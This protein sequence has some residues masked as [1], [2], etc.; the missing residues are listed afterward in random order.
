[1]AIRR[2]PYCKAII[3]ESQKYCNNCGT[4]LLFPDDEQVDEDLK[5]ERLV[6]EDFKDAEEEFDDSLEPR[7]DENVP[8]EVIDLEAV[9]EEGTGFPDEVN[10]GEKARVRS[11]GNDIAKEPEKAGEEAPL[12]KKRRTRKA[13][14]PAP[15]APVKAPPRRPTSN[16]PPPPPESPAPPPS[17]PLAPSPTQPPLPPLPVVPKDSCEFM[18]G[19]P[20]KDEEPDLGM[21][22]D[23][24]LPPDPDAEPEDDEEAEDSEK[25]G[26]EADTKEEIARLIE[27]LDK[28]Q[29]KTG[30]EDTGEKILAPLDASSDLPAWADLSAD[31]SA[32]EPV[33]EDVEER[34]EASSFVPGDTMDFQDEVMR[35]AEAASPSKATI[36]M[37][38]VPVKKD[39]A[40]L[41]DREE[42]EGPDI[43]VPLPIPTPAASRKPTPVL[44]APE[45]AEGFDS[46]G[47]APQDAASNNDDIVASRIGLGFFRRTAAIFFDLVFVAVLW[48]T[49]VGLAS[50][51][52][53]TAASDLVLAAT[54]PLGL[55]FSVLFAGYLFLFFFFLGETLGGRLMARRN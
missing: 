34:R 19:S 20:S 46:L 2:C 42:E 21:D 3:D 17:A 36:G 9:L 29:K 53:N 49:A 24:D 52:M 45:A 18:L 31:T 26:V 38:E 7:D 48:L 10:A 13:S 47:F 33:E 51:L 23:P 30:R 28:K 5:G 8:P 35:R 37:P 54:L 4:Q 44:A 15:S 43:I 25:R 39:S 50:L 55:L 6:D 11:V 41:F 12:P 22:P 27:T 1:M 16:L 32:P 14:L 40:Y